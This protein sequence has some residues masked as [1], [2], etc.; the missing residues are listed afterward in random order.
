MG[1]QPRLRRSLDWK[2][3][4][5]S[6]HL[7]ANGQHACPLAAHKNL[8]IPQPP[9]AS[10]STAPPLPEVTFLQRSPSQPSLLIT[11]ARPAPACQAPAPAPWESSWHR[12]CPH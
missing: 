7:V 12:P 4:K 1:R 5:V 2:A 6:F 9:K 3:G 11:W 8:F 10:F